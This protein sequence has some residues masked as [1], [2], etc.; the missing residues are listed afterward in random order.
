MKRSTV[1][2]ASGESLATCAFGTGAPAFQPA[3]L[4][5]GL[6]IV[7]VLLCA[8]LNPTAAHAAEPGGYITVARDVPV[9]GAFQAGDIGQPTNIATAREDIVLTNTNAI[10]RSLL[11]MSDAALGNVA[12]QTASHPDTARQMGGSMVTFGMPASS[13]AFGQGLIPSGS[14]P[15]QAIGA[16]ISGSTSPIGAAVS[17]LAVLK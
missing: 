14:R 8:S 17:G 7:Y 15:A 5:G 4:C 10:A 9:H 6:A 13:S 11:P 2:S 12:A 16:V 1:V 3:T